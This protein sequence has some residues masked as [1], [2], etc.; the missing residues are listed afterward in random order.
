MKAMILAA[1][2]G[3]RMR[4]LTDSLPKPLLRVGGKPLIV[5]QLERLAAAG[6][7][8]IVIN[9]AHLGH[10]MEEAL[11]DGRRFGVDIAY[12]HEAE[13][14]ETAGGVANA[15]HLLGGEPFA[16]L[17]ADI[18]TNY[19]YRHLA[20]IGQS[21]L[22][23]NR[24]GHL[25]LVDNPPFHPQGDFALDA[26]RVIRDGPRRYTYAN[27]GVFRPEFFAGVSPGSKAAMLPLMLSAIDVLRLG[28]ERYLGIWDNIG[29]PAQ[30]ESLDRRLG[31]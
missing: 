11:G 21:L 22:M 27:I 16:V 28:G 5:W 14:L 15:M 3:E 26:D 9:H 31:I 6:V 30:L 19:D 4:P 20:R 29:S 24:L 25:V 1:G 2:R 23:H 10:L 12:S 7:T 13:A 8:G 17:S 18:Y